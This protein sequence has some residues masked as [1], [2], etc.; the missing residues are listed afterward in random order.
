M[1]YALERLK[2]ISS[3]TSMEGTERYAVEDGR[4]P[5]PYYGA[6]LSSYSKEYNPFLGTLG[7][8][9]DQIIQNKQQERKHVLFADICGDGQL[10]RDHAKIN[11]GVGLTLFDERTEQQIEEDE[12]CGLTVFEGNLLFSSAWNLL[13]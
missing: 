12:R 4:R 6:G 1:S 5:W 3:S 9:L 11:H 2:L 10:V 8:T 13:Q 7:L